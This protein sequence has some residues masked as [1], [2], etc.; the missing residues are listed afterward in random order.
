MVDAKDRFLIKS[1]KKN[2][3]EF[4]GRGEVPAKGF[5]DNNTSA[6]VAVRFR[7]LFYYQT[8]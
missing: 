8:E 1:A 2:P 6:F 5:L 7:Q 3:V 4:L